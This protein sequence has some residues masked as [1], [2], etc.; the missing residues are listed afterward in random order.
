[1]P[2][3]NILESPT[4]PS[5]I[6][7]C[8]HISTS[9]LDEVYIGDAFV[10]FQTER[11]K[12]LG[13]D[14]SYEKLL[15]L[16]QA[17]YEVLDSEDPTLSIILPDVQDRI[18]ATVK[19]IQPNGL[20]LGSFEL[21]DGSFT[22]YYEIPFE[23]YE[24]TI[25]RLT[26]LFHEQNWW[27]YIKICKINLH[28]LSKEDVNKIKEYAKNAFEFLIMRPMDKEDLSFYHNTKDRHS[29][30]S[31]LD[32]DDSALMNIP[33]R[34]IYKEHKGFDAELCRTVATQV[35]AFW[36][37]QEEL[38]AT[39]YKGLIESIFHSFSKSVPDHSAKIFGPD[40]FMEPAINMMRFYS[41]ITKKL[42]L[43]FMQVKY[44]DLYKHYNT[45]IAN[46]TRPGHI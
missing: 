38:E 39:K 31:I 45:V 13:D 33:R 36:L 22:F 14:A 1:M 30:F 28:E 21:G 16:E 42:A 32:A 34:Y 15:R 3:S 25:D 4:M 26:K 37:K 35:Y 20:K 18:N 46:E 17:L 6:V 9:I 12:D 24:E 23:F 8:V 7:Q 19:D 40:L 43:L 5:G 29:T 2:L 41:S 44:P 11:F 27:K 10:E